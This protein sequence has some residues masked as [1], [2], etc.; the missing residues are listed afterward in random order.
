V[1]AFLLLVFL[2][3]IWASPPAGADPAVL[4]A[5]QA[6]TFAKQSGRLPPWFGLTDSVRL[7]WRPDYVYACITD[8]QTGA[9]WTAGGPLPSLRQALLTA[10]WTFSEPRPYT[11]ADRAVC[12]P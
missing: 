8:Q 6:I 2:Y 3:L 9:R 11:E 1:K 7:V 5:G 12:W 4:D 10:R